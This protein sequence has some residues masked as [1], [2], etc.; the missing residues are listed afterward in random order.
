MKYPTQPRALLFD[1]GGVLIDVD[2]RRAFRAWQPIST[3]SLSEIHEK[4]AFDTEYARHERGEITTFEYFDHLCTRLSLKP[5]HGPVAD[6]WNAIYVGA[7]PETIAMVSSVRSQ[8]ACYAFTNTNATHQAAWMARFPQ[9]TGLF[10]RVF[11]SHEMGCRKPE[12]RAFE[13][14]AR[15]VDVPV[16]SIL[17]FDDLPENVDGAR[18]AGLQAVQVRSPSDVRAKLGEIGLAL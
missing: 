18:A 15:E 5:E 12:K 16:G 2:F 7:I 11:S 4:F 17:F 3:L 13:Y 1:L 9:V 8:I 10:E 14:V 6:G